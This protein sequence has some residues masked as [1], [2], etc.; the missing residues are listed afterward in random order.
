[1]R[2]S[3]VFA[4]IPANGARTL[5]ARI[6]HIVETLWIE[7]IAEV[8]IYQARLHNGTQV[9]IIDLKDTV[10]TSKYNRYAAIN[11][12]SSTT[13]ACTCPPWYYRNI[14]VSCNFDDCGYL[15]CCRRQH[16]NVGC[17][18]IDR[19]IIL[20]QHQIVRGV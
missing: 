19:G 9:L 3:G 11:R 2:T 8:E 15:F 12:N 6:W 20:I 4:N 7:R 1:M 18:A 10:H 17:A 16:Y 13:Q 5:T 14:V